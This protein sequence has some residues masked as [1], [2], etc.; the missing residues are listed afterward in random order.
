MLSRASKEISLT[1]TC[2][3]WAQLLQSRTLG[4]RPW[5]TDH[6]KAHRG[7]VLGDGHERPDPLAHAL[8]LQRERRPEPLHQSERGRELDEELVFRSLRAS[9][10][11]QGILKQNLNR[12]SQWKLRTR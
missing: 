8:D 4:S 10:L 6:T 9:R 2:M 11:R 1:Q 12:K 7:V 5:H 3:L